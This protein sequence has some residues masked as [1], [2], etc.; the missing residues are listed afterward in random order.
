MVMPDMDLSVSGSDACAASVQVWIRFRKDLATRLMVIPIV[1]VPA[2]YLTMCLTHLPC[3]SPKAFATFEAI[4]SARVMS[5]V[6]FPM[7]AI[8]GKAHTVGLA[9]GL[10]ARSGCHE[11]WTGDRVGLSEVRLSSRSIF[12]I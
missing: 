10:G 9:L 4:L 1:L 8:I 7:Y 5:G 12:S 3:T 11:V 2:K 6:K